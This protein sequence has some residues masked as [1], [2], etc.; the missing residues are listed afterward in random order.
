VRG[1]F[2]DKV[3]WV[4]YNRVA[5]EKRATKQASAS[6]VLAR[7]E[8]G[9]MM[10]LRDRS[11]A[12]A[13]ASALVILPLFAVSSPAVLA[14]APPAPAT[15]ALGAGGEAFLEGSALLREG[16][17]DEGAVIRFQQ[18][19][20]EN[21]ELEPAW[22]YL[23]VALFKLGRFGEA[24]PALEKASELAQFRPGTRFYLGQIYE[25]VGDF[26]R[27]LAAYTAEVRIRRGRNVDEVMM[28]IGRTQMAA[29]EHDK[30]LVSLSRAIDRD[31]NYVEA[32][33]CRGLTYDGMGRYE[34]AVKEFRRAKEVLEERDRLKARLKRL[35][36]EARREAAMTEQIYAQEYA[37]AEDFDVNRRLRPQLSKALGQAY[38]HAGDY[39]LARIHYRASMSTAESGNTADP[40]ARVLIG[41]AYLN[42]GYETLLYEG[43]IK[44]AAIML[45]EGVKEFSTALTYDPNN[46]DAYVGIGRIYDL[47]AANYGTD[48]VRNIT[49]HTFDEAIA[50]VKKA[51]ELAP[52]NASAMK[53]LGAAY[54]HQGEYQ[55]ARQQL[56]AG[57]ALAPD[58]AGLY[59]H[60]AESLVGLEQY[61][62]AITQAETA[63]AMDHENYEALNAL[64]LAYYYL[65][66]L[67][68][69]IPSFERA[70][71]AQPRNHQG[72]T[73]LANAYFQSQSWH[74]ARE[75]YRRA[76][77]LIP[78]A[79]IA[80]TVFQR[81]YLQYLTG[82]AHANSGMHRSAI[83]SYNEALS[84]DGSYFDCILALAEAHLRAE[85][86]RAA[87]DALRAALSSSPGTEEDSRVHVLLGQVFEAARR[88]H[89]AIIEYGLALR[90]DPNNAS[91]RRALERLQQQITAAPPGSAG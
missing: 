59:A 45:D 37:R 20:Q 33:Y 39:E 54:N 88:P 56:E 83:R 48:R 8:C 15:P 31:A 14:Q 11:S 17:D 62:D 70:I 41:R 78:R 27:A 87:E 80:G 18:A 6:F 81:A 61:R 5:G 44:A 16:D 91:A 40:E 10:R 58:D 66:D 29:G 34:E 9:R 85:E 13:T 86:Y 30:A 77:E 55:L 71:R 50:A 2:V 69:A 47:Q 3:L 74:R 7:R 60:L 82:R 53:Y 25:A 79:T 32:Y 12:A 4:H 46:S 90:T 89:D 57:I 67:G 35:S 38:A 75:N 72:Y 64:G 84:L 28:G 65:G 42:E 52:D 21:E 22:Y 36:V 1:A 43:Q 51:L 26:E 73:N 24:I 19:V 49:S 68:R 63:L 76:L 23:G